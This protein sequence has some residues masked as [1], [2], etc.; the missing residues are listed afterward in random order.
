MTCADCE[1]ETVPQKRWQAMPIEQRRSSGL[2]RRVGRYCAAC[3]GR[4]S[5]G[6]EQQRWKTEELIEEAELLFGNGLL[7]AD[8]AKRLGIKHA[9]L[10]QAYRRA[11]LKG[12]TTRR[13]DYRGTRELH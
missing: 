3:S 8:V 10:I 5:R 6:T 7:A 11:R 1:A 2:K 4:R 13:P 12:L 9:S